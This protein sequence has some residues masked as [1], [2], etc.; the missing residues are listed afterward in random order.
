MFS[1]AWGVEAQKGFI[2]QFAGFCSNTSGC[3]L[4]GIFYYIVQIVNW[5]NA[6]ALLLFGVIALLLSVFLLS[7][8]APKIAG[9]LSMVAGFA[10]I[11]LHFVR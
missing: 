4:I 1:I 6:H 11:V 2:H 5:I 3:E 10:L 7:T 8:E 9:I